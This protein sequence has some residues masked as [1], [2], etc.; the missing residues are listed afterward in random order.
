MRCEPHR[1]AGDQHH[2]EAPLRFCLK[3]TSGLKE[4]NLPR[5]LFPILFQ[6]LLQV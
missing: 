6:I 5:D 3:F 1:R 4:F 2:V